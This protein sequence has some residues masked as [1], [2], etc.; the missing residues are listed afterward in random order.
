MHKSYLCHAFGLAL[1]TLSTLMLRGVAHAAGSEMT[2]GVPILVYHRFGPIAADSMTVTTPVFEK[3]LEWLRV[4]GYEIIPLRTVVDAIRGIAPL[5]IGH[6]VVITVDDGHRSVYTDLYPIIV[7]YRFPVT[8]FI[9]PSAIS[10]ASYAMTWEQVAEMARTGL[11]DVQSHT[12][13]HPNFHRE[14]LRLS[15]DR[16]KA[17]VEMQLVRSRTVIAEHVKRPVDMLA[18]PFGIYDPDLEKAAADAGYVAAFTLVRRPA[19][20]K[21]D[22]GSLP[23]YLITDQDRG[24]RFAAVAAGAAR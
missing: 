20:P 17:F 11:V 24:A 9:Y 12:Y 14:K 23:R 21:A 2:S 5:N 13:W 6:A 18:W 15:P 4:N 10:N 3:Q 8:L 19:I 1:L 16:Y 7:R 22:R